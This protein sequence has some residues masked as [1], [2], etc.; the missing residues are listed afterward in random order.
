MEFVNAHKTRAYFFGNMYL[1]PIQQGIQAAHVVTKLFYG[2][3]VESDPASQGYILY[4]W[5]EHGV[6]KILLN[7]GYQSNLQDIYAVFTDVAPELR[8]PFEKFHEETEALNGALTC[9]GIVVPEEVYGFD[10]DADVDSVYSLYDRL[11]A[12]G[13]YPPNIQDMRK[14]IV[15]K[16]ATPDAIR[17]FLQDIYAQPGAPALTEG[18]AILILHR[19]LKTCRLA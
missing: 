17:T 9:V 3:G 15:E 2:Y 8:L 4:Q 7:G 19:T 14:W 16:T 12:F 18:E 10:F 5:A 6:T 1:S 13:D 11:N